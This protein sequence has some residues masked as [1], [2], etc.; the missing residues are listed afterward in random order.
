MIKNNFKQIDL[1]RNRRDEYLLLKPNFIDTRRY[2]KKGIYLGLSLIIISI[3]VGFSFIVR[4]KILEQKKSSIKNFSDEYDS[5][6][7]KSDQDSKE[8][9]K[10]AE[11]NQKLKN[12]ISSI[13]S[14]SAFIKEISLLVPKNMQLISLSLDGDNLNLRGNIINKKPIEIVNSFLIRLDDSEFIKFNAIDL[15][16]VKS[17]KEDIEDK[18]LENQ[19]FEIN[20]KSKISDNNLNINQK[21]LDKLGSLGLSNRIKNLNYIFESTK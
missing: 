21:Y 17:I 5:L 15:T 10:L 19:T 18:T 1:L 8:L 4:T 9:K 6:V 7:F 13:N 14:S 20:I 11:F 3:S 2:I 16:N 12:S